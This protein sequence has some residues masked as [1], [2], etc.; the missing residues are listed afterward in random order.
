M[1][2]P[3]ISSTELF[4]YNHEHGVIYCSR[5]YEVI[6]RNCKDGNVAVKPIVFQTRF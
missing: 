1:P 2:I 5:K 3:V 6:F 4:L